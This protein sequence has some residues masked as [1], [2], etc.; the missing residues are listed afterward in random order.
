MI[1]VDFASDAERRP[2]CACRVCAATGASHSLDVQGDAGTLSLFLCADCGSYYFDGEAPVSGYEG[3]LADGFWLDY[4]QG[5]AGLIS[6]F[7]PLL[8]L[9][10]VPEGSL[11]DVGCGFGFVVDYW[12]RHHGPAIGLEKSAYGAIGAQSL[13]ADI[14]PQYLDDYRQSDPDSRHAIVYSSEVIEHVPDPGAF[15]DELVTM[16]DARSLLILT[17][18]AATAIRPDVDR[19]ELIAALSPHFHYAI[20]SEKILRRMLEERGLQVHIEIHGV[21][22]VA[23]ASRAPL[24]KIRYGRFDWPVYLDH[25]DQLAETDEPHLAIGALYRLFKDAMNS[26]HPEIAGRAWD[27]LLPRVRAVYGIDLLA[28]ELSGLM[29]ITTPLAQLDRYPSWLGLGLLF[30]AL[31]VGHQSNDRRLK[32]RM[33]DAALAVLRRRAEVDLQFGQEAR[34]CLPFA[35]RQYLIA[36]SEALTL[37]IQPQQSEGMPEDLRASLSIL[38]R[39]LVDRLPTDAGRDGE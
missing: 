24:P 27:R 35:E 26:G 4:V 2:R 14:R 5:G 22:M 3:G 23:W 7:S 8:A 19:A 18:P 21:Q 29:Q 32:L 37:G 17:T 10:P 31:H 1:E 11:I 39:E 33:L 12:T 6:M 36:L 25:L 16:L 13:G 15:L 9:D 30:G 20:L 38:V 34:H 28:P